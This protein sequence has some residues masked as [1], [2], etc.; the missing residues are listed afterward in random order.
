VLKIYSKA[1]IIIS[2]NANS[3]ATLPREFE[4]DVKNLRE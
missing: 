1:T 4:I 2:L 3:V